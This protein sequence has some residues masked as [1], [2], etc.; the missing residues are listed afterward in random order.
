MFISSHFTF[1]DHFFYFIFKRKIT[2]KGKIVTL[3]GSDNLDGS[4]PF[5][6]MAKEDFPGTIFVDFSPKGGPPNLLGVFD[7][8]ANAI[9]VIYFL[10]AI[11]IQYPIAI[12][13]WLTIVIME[14]TVARWQ[15]LEENPV[16]LQISR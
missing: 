8:T 6:I 12:M 5:I 3:T 13:K 10:T 9:K 1:L 15:L 16:S 7:E 14:T 11:C 2:N 4:K